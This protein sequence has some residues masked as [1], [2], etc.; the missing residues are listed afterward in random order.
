MAAT[1][2]R[3]AHC[4]EGV[5]G[6]GGREV[7]AMVT[8]SGMTATARSTSSFITNELFYRMLTFALFNLEK[9]KMLNSWKAFTHASVNFRSNTRNTQKTRTF[10]RFNDNNNNCSIHH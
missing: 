8:A 6:A 2:L 10:Q 1:R 7:A 5:P 4:V 3:P 9:R